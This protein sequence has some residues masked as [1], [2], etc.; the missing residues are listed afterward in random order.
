M[1]D[2]RDVRVFKTEMHNTQE[3]RTYVIFQ[4]YISVPEFN[5]CY[6]CLVCV[7]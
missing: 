2:I 3:M 6:L 7:L 4:S 5:M 1:Q